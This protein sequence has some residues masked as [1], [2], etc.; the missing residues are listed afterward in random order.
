MTTTNGL[1]IQ[2]IKEAIHKYDLLIHPYIIYCHPS[3]KDLLKECLGDTQMIEDIPWI[4]K[5]KVYLFD[6]AKIEEENKKWFEG[7]VDYKNIEEYV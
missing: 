7:F 1:T 3:V 2:D 4:E 6:R 5:D